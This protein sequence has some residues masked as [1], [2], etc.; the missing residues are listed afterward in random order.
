MPREPVLKFDEIHYWSEIKL[1]IV[2]DYAAAYTRVMQ[3][4]QR[5]GLNLHFAYID[6]F[7]GA[8]VHI[9]KATGEFVPG[10]PTNA[11]AV[12]P[13]FKEFVFIDMDGAKVG[14]LRESVGDRSDVRIYEGDCN[15]ILVSDVLPNIT[16]ENY[17]RALC[18]LDPYGLHLN[19]EVIEKA[20]KSRAIDMFLNFPVMDMNRNALWKNPDRVGQHGIERMN[21]FWGDESWRQIVY[22]PAPQL[23]FFGEEVEKVANEQVVEAFVERLRSVAGFTEV[24]PPMEMRNS[25][26]AIVY[27]LIFASQKSVAKCIVTDIFEKYRNR[28]VTNV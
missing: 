6:A 17:R 15:T 22:Q 28:Q 10:S 2:K 19:W 12:D 13:A 11:L 9:S 20:G 7:S 5:K 3:G 4:Q 26:G 27:Y 16:Y 23:S 24:P 8:G 18:L 25:K 14:Q 21:A 1:D